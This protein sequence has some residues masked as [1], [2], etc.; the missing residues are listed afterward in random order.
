MRAVNFDEDGLFSQNEKIDP[1]A[2]DHGLELVMDVELFEQV[3]ELQLGRVL[4]QNAFPLI[5]EEL[6]ERHHSSS[7][8]FEPSQLG[9]T[10]FVGEFEVAGDGHYCCLISSRS[11]AVDLKFLCASKGSMITG[12]IASTTLDASIRYICK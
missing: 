9:R 6:G 2:T 7:K 3:P 1:A 4:G 12:L 5:V 8:N 10:V 11:M